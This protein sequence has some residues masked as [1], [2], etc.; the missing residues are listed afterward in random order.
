MSLDSSFWLDADLRPE[1]AQAI[2]VGAGIFERGD[3]YRHGLRMFADGTILAVSPE[4]SAFGPFQE[5]GIAPTLHFFFANSDNEKTRAWTENTV[6]AVVALLD[7]V[8]GDALL[9]YCS[10]SPALLRKDGKIVLDRRCGLW[11]SGV[12]PEVLSLIA[13]PYEFG[14]IPVT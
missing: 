12:E 10:D 3:S 11:Q 14:I 9:L 4:R 6:R 7:S 5:A 8:A 13:P 2:L 1:G